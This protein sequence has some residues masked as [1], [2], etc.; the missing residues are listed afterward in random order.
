MIEVNLKKVFLYTLI[1]TFFSN[2]ICYSNINKEVLKNNTSLFIL[3]QTKD[4]LLDK[5][6]NEIFKLYKKEDYIKALKEALVFSEKVK[7]INNLEFSYK[8]YLLVADI[9]DKTNDH[10][11]SLSYY[12]KSLSILVSNYLKI[13]K[14]SVFSNIHFSKTYL[15]IGSSFQKQQK[16]DSARYYYNK[17]IAIN[18]LNDD[19]LKYQAISYTN[20]SG[21][22]ELDSL[23]DKAEEYVLKAIKI[24]KERNDKLNQAS[25][26]NNL[27]NIYLSKN[28][29][30]KAK[31]TY[32]EGVDLIDKDNSPNAVRYKA[33]LYYNLAWVMRNL[34]DYKAYDFQERSYE[35]ED[36][37]RDKEIRT[38]IETVTAQYDVD[39]VKKAEEL[40]RAKAE[41]TTWIISIAS[42]LV[43]VSLLYFLNFYKLKQKI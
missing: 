6:Y 7:L 27:G 20:L 33:N 8:S 42:L 34:K 28:E 39:V 10:K 25:A 3:L 12:K 40:K 2:T 1:L 30:S 26:L 21:I 24:H 19:V 15:R 37:L 22:L 18:S 41:K 43:I 23:Y 38:M 35:I 36:G 32:L 5:E 13:E 31:N 29:F 14:Q 9:Y 17:N 16:N 11:K 4:S